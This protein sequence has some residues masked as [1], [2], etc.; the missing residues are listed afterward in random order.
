MYKGVI[1]RVLPFFLTFAGGLLVASFFVTVTAPNFAVG[2]RSGR[3]TRCREAKR[4]QSEYFE[5]KR[6]NERLRRELDSARQNIGA[7]L[8][9]M[10]PPP[11][12][13]ENIPQPPPRVRTIR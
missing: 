3:Y 1:K 13:P 7:D 12:V 8:N 11:F 4:Y 2:G 10:V 6:E 9:E 5:L